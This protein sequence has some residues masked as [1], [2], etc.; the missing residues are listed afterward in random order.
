MAANV[1]IYDRIP[2][3]KQQAINQFN[4]FK[5]TAKANIAFY[6]GRYLVLK[7]AKSGKY[8]GY[9]MSYIYETKPKRRYIK[10]YKFP[11]KI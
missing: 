1:S 2:T 5:K 6:L 4:K 3:T 11:K 7:R 9:Y 8:K 10:I